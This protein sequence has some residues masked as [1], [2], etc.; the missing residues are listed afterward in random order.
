M[1]GEHVTECTGGAYK[2][3]DSDLATRYLTSCDPRLNAD[4]VLELA[5]LIADAFKQAEPLAKPE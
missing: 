2:I 1:T 5:Y 3:S 4:Q